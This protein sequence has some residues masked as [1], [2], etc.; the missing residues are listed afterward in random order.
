MLGASEWYDVL[1]MHLL[2][3]SDAAW[4]RLEAIRREAERVGITRVAT[5]MT[6]LAAELLLLEDDAAGARRRLDAVP[7]VHPSVLGTI[8]DRGR[9]TWA[10]VLVATG[11]PA[12]ALRILEPLA[13]E[14]RGGARFGR[15]VVTLVATAI[16]HD[17]T[18]DPA[19]A[20]AALG[21]AVALAADEGYRRAFLD[22]ALPLRGLLH[23][24]RRVHPPFVDRLISG[25]QD[26]DAERSARECGPATRG[27]RGRAPVDP[28]SVRE[29]EVLRLVAA[30]LSNDEI[31]RA[32]FI[33]TGTAKWH[34]HNV[35]AKLGARNRVTVVARAREHGLV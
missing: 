14:Q 16:A 33:S 12:E 20:T 8:R 17:R 29:L 18:G 25:R 19:A 26:G 4:R 28:L 3:E 22:P 34:V 13:F 35:I 2:G 30:G 5:A 24:V 1:G 23:L 32:L 27:G 11:E 6:L 10:R 7:S 31:G 21:D 9:Q 15:L